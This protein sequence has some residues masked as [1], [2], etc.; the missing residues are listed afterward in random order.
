MSQLVQTEQPVTCADKENGNP[1]TTS[2]I[3]PTGVVEPKTVF[4]NGP[5]L[6]RKIFRLGVL[7]IV[8]GIL[9]VCGMGLYVG[10]NLGAPD[11]T[12]ALY[13]CRYILEHWK[14][15]D[16]YLPYP[17]YAIPAIITSCLVCLSLLKH[18]NRIV[19]DISY[20]KCDN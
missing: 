19:S 1:P 12:E 20:S 3:P 8:C 17:P 7:Q 2:I 4:I 16:H 15:L 13:G 10:I 9:M 14:F 11:D 6:G 18:V 5:R